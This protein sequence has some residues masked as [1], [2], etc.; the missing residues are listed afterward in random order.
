[1]YKLN[2]SDI[3]YLLLA[4]SRYQEQTGSEEMWDVYNELKE[5]LYTYR[6]QN[7]NGRE[8]NI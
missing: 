6:E 2:S 1:M 8:K 3:D 4:C 7:L 5:K